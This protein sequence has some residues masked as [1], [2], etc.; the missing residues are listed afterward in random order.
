[1]RLPPDT[2]EHIRDAAQVFPIGYAMADV[3]P[4]AQQLLE[5][6]QFAVAVIGRTLAS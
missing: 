1:V 6:E 4:M 3:H 5:R 2:T